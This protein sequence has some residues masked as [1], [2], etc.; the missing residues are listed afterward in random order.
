MKISVNDT[1]STKRSGS[2]DGTR[3]QCIVWLK[4]NFPGARIEG[5]A[6]LVGESVIGEIEK[7]EKPN[8]KSEDSQK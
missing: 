2:F 5:D 4:S 8:G 1:F 3:A 6:V 7:E